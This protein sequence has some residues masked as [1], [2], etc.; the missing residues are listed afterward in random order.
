MGWYNK[1]KSF[2]AFLGVVFLL[3]IAVGFFFVNRYLP[4]VKTIATT[5][6]LIEEH[7]LHKPAISD[8]LTGTAAGLT[9]A[10]QD[11]YSSYLLKEEWQELQTKIEDNLSG[12]GVY[13]SEDKAGHALVVS[14]IKG[15]PA[16][17]AGVKAGDIFLEVDKRDI[18]NMGAT[19]VSVLIRGGADT[20]VEIRI[21]RPEEQKEYE[22]AIKR[23]V[24]NLPSVESRLLEADPQIGYIRLMQFHDNSTKEM[25]QSLQSLEQQ[26]VHKLILD[27]RDNGGGSFVSSLEIA[28]MF[29]T[30]GD[31]VVTEDGTGRQE[32][33]TATAGGK[34]WPLVVLINGNSA[35][36]S[37]I[38]AGALKDNRRATLVG[39]TSF[40]KG[41][42]QTVFPLP[43]GGAV[44][45]TTQKYYTPAG[46]DINKKGIEPDIEIADDLLASEDL[47]LQKAIDVLK[48]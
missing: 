34:D 32:T 30:E 47:Q 13:I 37:E 25:L 28:D 21:L 9:A 8:F 11:P 40:G 1:V 44:K 17:Q 46:N 2:L 24:I 7:A 22:F 33:Y 48:K 29:L 5:Y 6:C 16:E 27:L 3:V 41:L 38:L 15:G 23:A 36:A 43:D 35:S 20:I 18:L 12:I 19:E 45:L 26:G 42:V 4:E 31:I 10:L 39:E 14:V